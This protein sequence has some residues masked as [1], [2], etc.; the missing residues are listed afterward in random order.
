MTTE[1]QD[2]AL[3]DGRHGLPGDD[4]LFENAFRHAPIGMAL[5]SLEGLF[6]RVNDAFCAMLGYSAEEM[7]VC[8]FQTLTHADDLDADLHLLAALTEGRL[9][10]YQ[11]EKRYIRKDATE[12][13]VRLSVSMVS[14]AVG[15]PLHYIAQV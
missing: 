2:P 9:P 5:V 7:L 14:D 13:W 10:H 3:Q 15:R 8:D 11:M 12:V 4:Q 6:L 1:A